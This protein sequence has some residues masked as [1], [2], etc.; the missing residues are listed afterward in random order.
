[1]CA[2]IGLYMT[3]VE[4]RLLEDFDLWRIED[5]RTEEKNTNNDMVD[6]TADIFQVEDRETSI[7]D[8]ITMISPDVDA[9]LAANGV[10]VNAMACKGK[11]GVEGAKRKRATDDDIEIAWKHQNGL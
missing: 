8:M 1:M 10:R 2:I 4:E 3:N 6:Y 11:E 5:K 9:S 7:L